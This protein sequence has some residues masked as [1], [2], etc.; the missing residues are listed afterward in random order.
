MNHIA[1]FKDTR[2]ADK[3]QI[4]LMLDAPNSKEIRIC[5]Q[6][7]NR[8]EEHTAPGA[9]VI[10]VLD[11]SVNIGSKEG[12]VTLGTGEA[13]YFAA[14]APH[15]LEATE[16]SVIRLSLSKNDSVRRVEGLVL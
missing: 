8:M 7:G 16:D 13:V 12:N 5:M 4:D 11:G 15:S 3:P 6:K 14:Y 10:M 9:I 1:F 2:F